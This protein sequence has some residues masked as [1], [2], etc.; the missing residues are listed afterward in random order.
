MELTGATHPTDASGSDTGVAVTGHRLLSFDFKGANAKDPP[1]TDEL[2]FTC[3]RRE[4]P[5]SMES[6]GRHALASSQH[7][8]A[9][10]VETANP[11]NSQ[12]CVQCVDQCQLTWLSLQW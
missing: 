6:E 2:L 8:G 7:T 12:V 5:G 4:S 3:D 9:E 1:W 10:V 11:H